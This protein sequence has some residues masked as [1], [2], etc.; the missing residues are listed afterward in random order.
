MNTLAFIPDDLDDDFVVFTGE[1]N[2]LYEDINL[3]L[4]M[5]P[6][7][8]LVMADT[9]RPRMSQSGILTDYLNIEHMNA[10]FHGLYDHFSPYDIIMAIEYQHQKEDLASF[11]HSLSRIPCRDRLEKR[12]KTQQ[13]RSKRR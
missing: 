3:R 13:K 9:V 1:I 12:R 10:Y 7:I 2:P 6:R 4:K 5:R 11:M 8:P